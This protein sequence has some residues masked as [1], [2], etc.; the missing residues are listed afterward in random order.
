[1]SFRR[2]A[3]IVTDVPAA[4]EEIEAIAVML[5]T[6]QVLVLP[7]DV[8]DIIIV[9][10]LPGSHAV[11]S[12]YDSRNATPFLRRDPLRLDPAQRTDAGHTLPRYRA[13]T[14][15]QGG[16]NED[17]LATRHRHRRHRGHARFRS[18]NRAGGNAMR[19]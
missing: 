1:M 8:G 12:R 3:D 16:L 5:L 2:A 7:L 6:Q 14:T 11:S 4:F 15:P 17:V 9:E 13:Y 10:Q 19:R 18:G